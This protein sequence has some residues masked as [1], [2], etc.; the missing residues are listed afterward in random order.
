MSTQKEVELLLEKVLDAISE[1]DDTRHIKGI[2]F[3]VRE[4]RR[5]NA[6]GEQGP[7]FENLIN[8]LYEV[9]F[10]ITETLYADL[11]R[12]GTLMNMDSDRWSYLKKLIVKADSSSP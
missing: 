1:Y 2:D 10:P 8:N 4:A 3:T 6:H 7:A 12:L 5:L 11:N 9:D